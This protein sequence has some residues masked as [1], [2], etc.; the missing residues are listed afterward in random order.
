MARIGVVLVYLFGLLVVAASWLWPG[1]PSGLF[2]IG[3]L[4]VLQGYLLTLIRLYW[5]KI[6]IHTKGGWVRFSERPWAYRSSFLILG[7]FW[8]IPSIWLLSDLLLSD[9]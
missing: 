2:K 4:V 6:D 1:G 7:W 8:L 5:I 3:M 9:R